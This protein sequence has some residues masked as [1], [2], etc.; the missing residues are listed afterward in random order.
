MID[1][2]RNRNAYGRY[3]LPYEIFNFNHGSWDLML[4]SDLQELI[5]VLA[6]TTRNQLTSNQLLQLRQFPLKYNERTFHF[7]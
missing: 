5:S 6:V 3:S 2:V 7:H 1:Y 4:M